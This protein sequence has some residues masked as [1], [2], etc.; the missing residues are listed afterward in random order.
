MDYSSSSIF[1]L[2]LKSTGNR[3]KKISRY[4]RVTTI[5]IDLMWKVQMHLTFQNV[6]NT[7]AFVVLTAN[8]K[9]FY[10]YSCMNTH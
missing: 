7:D 1:N 10:Y 5:D 6:G 3:I 8:A 4:R 2:N 9:S